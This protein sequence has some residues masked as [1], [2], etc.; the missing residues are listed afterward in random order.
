MLSAMKITDKPRGLTAP[1]HIQSVVS[2]RRQFLQSVGILSGAT[3]VGAY[4][5][6][7]LAALLQAPAAKPANAADLMRAQLGAA[8]IETTP[9]GERMVMLSGPGGNVAVLY[10]P[11]GKI[12][13]DSFV[14]P[15]WPR[16]KTTLDGLD[17]SPIKMVIDT[18]WHFDHSDNNANFRKAGAEIVAHENT[19]KRMS[20]AHD[21]PALGLRF[22][23]SPAEALPTDTFASTR[24][25]KANGEEIALSHVPPAHTDTDILVHYRK[26]NVLHM[27]DLFFNGMYPFIDATTAGNING[28]IAASDRA[29]KMTNAQTKIIPGHGPLADRTA[30]E[31][32]RTMM[33]TVR[34]TVGALKK[35]GQSLAEVQAAKP[36]AS[37]DA[38]WG[39]GF[40][41]PDAFVAL[42]FNTL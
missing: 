23:P 34:D 12:A 19:K 36:T 4:V 27:G 10:G 14:M 39:K 38:V 13:V 2:S 28:M 15:A 30:L 18:H 8:P 26:A 3:F 33:V 17:G 25:V 22:D 42:V 24:S 31:K 37:L 11:D 40:V 9:L 6:A 7:D 16:L 21:I 41:A 1:R 32:Y 29:L 35:K 20:Q 5:E